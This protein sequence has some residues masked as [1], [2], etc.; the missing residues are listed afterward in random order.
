MTC[1]LSEANRA[2]DD[3]V[4]GRAAPRTPL[5]Y[6]RAYRSSM[7]LPIA[8]LGPWAST[9]TRQSGRP[10]RGS[11]SESTSGEDAA[12]NEPVRRAALVG[13]SGHVRRHL[14]TIPSPGIGAAAALSAPVVGG[15]GAG[16][17]SGGCSVR[18]RP[19]PRSTA[20]GRRGPRP[21]SAQ[22]RSTCR[23]YGRSA[24]PGPRRARV[25]PRAGAQRSTRARTSPW[26]NLS[27]RHARVQAPRAS[28]PAEEELVHLDLPGWWVA[29]RSAARNHSRSGVR[30]PRMTVPAVT[31]VCW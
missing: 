7:I 27:R 5:S 10:L 14:T 9:S 1:S 18:Q 25:Q 19:G 11:G 16:L 17:G 15:C 26:R 20:G 29:T 3:H 6:V 22:T 23:G 13:P 24:C 4:S 30:V 31:D 21:R 2:A 8:P 28:E 12:V